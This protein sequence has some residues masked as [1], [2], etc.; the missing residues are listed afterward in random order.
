MCQKVGNCARAMD[1]SG[2]FCGKNGYNSSV[3][4]VQGDAE[5]GGGVIGGELHSPKYRGFGVVKR[6]YSN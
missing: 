1:P 4:P 2:P 6:D 3:I 5:E